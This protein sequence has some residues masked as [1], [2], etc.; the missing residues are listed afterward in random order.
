MAKRALTPDEM[1]A[2]GRDMIRKAEEKR[3]KSYTAIGRLCAK[4]VADLPADIQS[5]IKKLLNS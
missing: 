2:K 4:R 1:I 5:E 3:D